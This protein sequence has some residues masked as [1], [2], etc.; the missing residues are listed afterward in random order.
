MIHI[1]SRIKHTQTNEYN[2]DSLKGDIDSFQ[3]KKK[4]KGDI[5]RIGVGPHCCAEMTTRAGLKGPIRIAIH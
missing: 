4:K 1:N 3:K 2:W 5:D